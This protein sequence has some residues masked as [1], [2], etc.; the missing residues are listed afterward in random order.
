MW[1]V[2]SALRWLYRVVNGVEETEA[3]EAQKERDGKRD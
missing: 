1:A 3:V 2:G